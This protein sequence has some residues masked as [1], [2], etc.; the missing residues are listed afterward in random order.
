MTFPMEGSFSSP[1]STPPHPPHLKGLTSS[2]LL[3]MMKNIHQLLTFCWL[4]NLRLPGGALYKS[5]LFLGHN[6][7]KSHFFSTK[8]C[9]KTD[10]WKKWTLSFK[11]ITQEMNDSHHV[12]SVKHPTCWIWEKTKT[13]ESWGRC[14]RM[15]GWGI[16]TQIHLYMDP[17]RLD[18]V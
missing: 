14:G 7:S 18:P 3:L 15:D 1:P 10:L 4:K 8:R 17:I 6:I 16:P 12:V 9:F 13:P 2:A 11:M 5:G